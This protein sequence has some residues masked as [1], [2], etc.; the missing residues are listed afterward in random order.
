MARNTSG[1]ANTL[2][3]TQFKKLIKLVSIGNNPERNT[4]ILYFSYFLGLRAKEISN[5]KVKDVSGKNIL[6]LQASYTKGNKHRDIPL[7]NKTIQ[8]VI[9]NYVSHLE[10]T[11]GLLFNESNALFTSQKGGAFSANAM[12]RLI[13]NLYK[14]NGY[15]GY[16]SHSGRRSMITNLVNAGISINKVKT[17][18]G[19]S[20]IQTTMEYV[21]TNMDDLSKVMAML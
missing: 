3:E 13:N 20:N 10:K 9:K 17:L 5:I 2:S 4:S 8:K 14:D 18:A 16:S 15:D 11:R 12:V 1:K 6:K 7:S 21:D 19:H